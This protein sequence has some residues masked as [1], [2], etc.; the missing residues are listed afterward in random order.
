MPRHWPTGPEFGFGVKDFRVP[1]IGEENP[2]VKSCSGHGAVEAIAVCHQGPG[3]R[4]QVVHVALP[5]VLVVAGKDLLPGVD[6]M[7]QL[8]P[9]FTDKNYKQ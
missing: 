5:R 8:R 7:N 6:I 1:G 4:A 3:V 2:A 9:H